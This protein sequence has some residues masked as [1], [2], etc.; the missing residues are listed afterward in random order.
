VNTVIPLAIAF[1]FK[2]ATDRQ[3]GNREK[4]LAAIKILDISS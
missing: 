1:S 3:Q 4:F 2:I